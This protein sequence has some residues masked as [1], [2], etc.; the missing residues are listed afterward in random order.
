MALILLCLPW[1]LLGLYLALFVRVPPELDSA[2]GV[3][4][5]GLPSVSIIVPARNEEG[6]LPGLLSSLTAM[7]YPDF[8]I[9]VV[10]DQS[11]DGTAAAV[12]GAVEGNAKALRL[13]QGRALPEGWFGKPWAC[14]QGAREAKG[15]LLLF[16]DADTRHAPDLLRKAVTTMESQEADVLTLLGQQVM[17]SFWERVL[18]P[19]F[20]MLL[21]ARY[22]GVGRVRKPHH[23]RHAIANGQ[24]LLFRRGAYEGM[25]GHEAVKGEV[26][27]DMR[28]AQLL[29]LG[30]WR[31]L[32]RGG[33]GLSTRMYTSL[34]ELM[35][36]WGK[37][38]TTGAL[39]STARWLLPIIL[40]LSLVVGLGLWLL[41]P[42]VLVWAVVSG[43]GGLPF[44]FGL[45][46]TG[47][48]VLYWG[49]ASGVMRGNPLYGLLY[50]LGSVI[51]ATIFVRS[52][53]RGGEI[54]WKGRQYDVPK[55]ARMVEGPGLGSVSSK[56]NG[57]A[58]GRVG[59]DEG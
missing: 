14:V 33:R 46:M 27:E 18:Q 22:P 25:G 55:E 15:D 36:G 39:Q 48:G 21:A 49:L 42:G 47:F 19:Q 44:N 41:P 43:T 13:I 38:I 6:N 2:S 20:F 45:L 26:V 17:D 3:E 12:V 37:N 57:S 29:V 40:P 23:W 28:I 53:V 9:L 7:E 1:L 32:V 24:Y 30:G 58:G 35:D 52:W 8:E 10:D 5:S 51:A 54:H 16:T 34:P 56:P 31:L 11:E 4:G 50:P 59:G